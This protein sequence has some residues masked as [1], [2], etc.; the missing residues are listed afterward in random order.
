MFGNPRYIHPLDVPM[1]G[2]PPLEDTV[3]LP[4][5]HYDFYGPPPPDPPLMGPNPTLPPIDYSI[6]PIGQ[7]IAFR[8]PENTREAWGLPPANVTVMNSLQ[9]VDVSVDLSTCSLNLN[10]FQ[11]ELDDPC[12]DPWEE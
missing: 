5:T 8:P 10:Y 3:V 6:K 12:E 9:L 1:Y 11:E 7:E 2:P 4:L